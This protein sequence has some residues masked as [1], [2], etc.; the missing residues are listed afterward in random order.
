M[1]IFNLATVNPAEWVATSGS[2]RSQAHSLRRTF[3]MSQFGDPGEIAQR[4]ILSVGAGPAFA[5]ERNVSE[6]LHSL[7][8]GD[9]LGYIER[10]SMLS[11]LSVGHLFRLYSYTPEKL[12]DAPSGVEICDANEV[13]EYDALARYFDIGWATLASDFFRYAM[14]AKGLGYWVDLDLYFVRPLDFQDEYVFGWEHETKING[15]VLRLPQDSEMVRELCEIPHINWRPPYYGL[16]KSAGLYLKR[17]VQ[18]DVRPENYRWG[19][20][21]PTYLTYLAK[22]HRVSERAQKRSVFYPIRHRQAKLACGPPELVEKQLTHETRAIHLW[23]SVL[24]EAKVSPPPG[25][26]LEAVCRRHGLDA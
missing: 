26:Y 16:R 14:L 25:S 17:M 9:R 11:A 18:G 5:A 12:S 3:S 22:K 20:F 7:W 1:A 4:E 2:K 8:I 24:G 10:L 13:I 21:G 19:A 15:A 6:R 23:C